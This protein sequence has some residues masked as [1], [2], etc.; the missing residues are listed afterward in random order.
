MSVRIFEAVQ[1]WFHI[2][3]ILLQVGSIN[4]AIGDLPESKSMGP[5]HAKVGPGH[6]SHRSG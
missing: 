1:L 2:S 3:P 6:G 4:E 5:P